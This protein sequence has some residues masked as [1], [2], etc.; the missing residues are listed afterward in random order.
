MFEAVTYYVT[1]ITGI[2]G[3]EPCPIPP[4]GDAST[5]RNV[6]YQEV[7][8]RAELW[9]IDLLTGT[10]TKLQWTFPGKVFWFGVSE[11]G[12]YQ[13]VSGEAVWTTAWTFKPKPD[14]SGFDNFWSDHGTVSA[15]NVRYRNLASGVTIGPSI[16]TPSACALNGGG[17][18]TISPSPRVTRGG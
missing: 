18:G 17:T 11:D 6:D 14:G 9:S 2:G 13:G 12:A 5:C 10:H 8:E 15:C 16:A 3:W 7:S 1:R 4:G